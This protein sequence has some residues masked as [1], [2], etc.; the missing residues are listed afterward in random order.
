M[1]I[2]RFSLFFTAVLMAPTGAHSKSV[3][4]SGPGRTESCGNIYPHAE[5][6]CVET[7][8]ASKER[9]MAKLL[10]RARNAVKLGF[11]QHGSFDSRTSP[12]FLDASQTEWKRFVDSNCTVIASYSGGSN[13]AISDRLADCYEKELDARIE[14]LREAAEGTG[15]FGL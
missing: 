14:F 11:E 3:E 6:T 15:R 4:A 9:L 2:F 10:V 13:S 12:R 8:I 5:R 1:T 7:R